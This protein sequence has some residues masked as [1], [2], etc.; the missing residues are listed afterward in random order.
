M[1]TKIYLIIVALSISNS[2]AQL[3]VTATSTDFSIDFDTS[4]SGVNEGAYDGTGFNPAPSTGD[5]DGNAWEITGFSL[6]NQAYD[7]TSTSGDMARG[8]STGEVASGGLYAFEV[9]ASDFAFGMQPTGSDFTPGTITLKVTNNTGIT[10]SDIEIAYE[11]WNLNNADRANSLNFSYST[12][13]LFYTDIG[14]LDYTSPEAPNA[15][16]WVKNDRS[17]VITG[18]TLDNGDTLYLRWTGSDESGSAARDEFAI[19]DITVNFANTLSID[20]SNFEKISIYTINNSIL[21]DGLQ[22]GNTLLDVYNILGKLVNTNTFKATGEIQKI[23]LSESLDQGIYIVR[24]KTEKG[25]LSKKI[26]KR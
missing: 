20:D 11:I 12:D 25:I 23:E 15:S 21:I 6:G 18:L 5:L 9:A 24:L 7:A 19:D 14:A 2:W 17:T 4:I 16:S 13:D 26:I 3:S 8:S 10:I 22:A 1:K